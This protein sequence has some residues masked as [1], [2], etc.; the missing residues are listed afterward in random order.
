[1]GFGLLAPTLAW[2]K[3]LTLPGYGVA[4][5]VYATVVGLAMVLVP[6]HRGRYLAL[7]AAWL[8]AEAI[9]GAWPFGGVP[10]SQ[11]AIGQVAGPLAG[12]ARIGGTLL[13]GAL[14]A[15][16]GVAVS[17]AL[18]RHWRVAGGAAAVVV[19]VAGAAAVAPQ[20]HDTGRTIRVALV[21]GGGPQG[22]RARDTDPRDVF[23][24]HLRASEMVPKGMDLVVWPEDVVDTPSNVADN[25]EGGELS[26]LAKRLRATLLAG[27]V[28]T[29]DEAHFHN[30]VVAWDAGGHLVGR[31]EKV[32][33]VPFGEWVPFRSLLEKVAG[34]SLPQR[35]AIVG[36]K[37]PVLT[38]A[39][40]TLGVVISWEVFFGSRA[41]RAVQHGGQILLNP[42]NGSSFTGTLVQTQQVASSRLRAIET[43]RWELQV[44]PTGFSA[45]ITPDGHVLQRTALSQRAVRTHTVALRSGQTLYTRWGDW[46][47]FLAGLAALAAAWAWDRRNRSAAA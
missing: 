7:P 31:Y 2:I 30:A 36:T 15:G 35:D 23:D 25:P 16:A 11:L 38:T 24:R 28:E 20:G 45:F 13:I 26:A 41:R 37:P 39:A 44:A 3:E 42:T 8:V 10:L 22:T 9:R 17:A 12:V 18:R 6:P 33:R 40:G 14:T 43:G 29:E 34:G 47:T 46:P 19:L 27:V 4:V 21:Q 1:M 32:H 5:V